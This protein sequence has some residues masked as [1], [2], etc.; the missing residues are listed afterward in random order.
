MR[1]T[2]RPGDGLFAVRCGRLRS[3]QLRVFADPSRSSR[4][5]VKR[6][7]RVRRDT[8]GLTFEAVSDNASAPG[9]VD[10]RVF[11]WVPAESSYRVVWT[12]RRRV[13]TER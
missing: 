5:L 4:Y 6:V 11:G 13:R 7:G 9:V 1:P 10:S 8:T 3:G 12:V 2:L